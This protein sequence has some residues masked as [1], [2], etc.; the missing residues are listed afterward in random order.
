MLNVFMRALILYIVVVISMRIM[1]KRQIGQMQPFEFVIA[2]LMADLA[3]VPMQNTGI[4]L[5]NGI[6]PILTLLIAQLT[7][8]Y[9]TMKSEK[10][11]G[12]ICGIP[13]ILIQHGKIN[14]DVLV[15]LRYDL[16]DLIEQLRSKDIANI[17]DVEFAILETSGHLS[18]FPKVENKPVT[19]K[20]MNLKKNPEDIPLTLILDGHINYKNLEKANKDINWLNTQIKNSGFHDANQI[21]LAELTTEKQF[22]FQEKEKYSRNKQK[23]I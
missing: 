6:I 17:S 13:S 7:L 21:L 19:L 11:R 16:N 1:G 8:S 18:V 12:F 9:I 10:A 4:P 3:A 5:I 14:E 23:E 20:D 15:K 2:L 22:Y